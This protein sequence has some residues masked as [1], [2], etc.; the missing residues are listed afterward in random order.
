MLPRLIR[1]VL[2]LCAIALGS[3]WLLLPGAYA[4]QAGPP[5]YVIQQF[6]YKNITTDATT[7]VKSG[8]GV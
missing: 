1:S 6:L 3:S 4:Q 7:T 5:T 2:C 8:S